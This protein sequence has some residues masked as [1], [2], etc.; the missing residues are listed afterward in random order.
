METRGG[1]LRAFPWQLKVRLENDCSRR[2]GRLQSFMHYLHKVAKMTA[3]RSSFDELNYRKF[4]K[5]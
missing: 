2:A 5:M 3:G 4:A 1:L